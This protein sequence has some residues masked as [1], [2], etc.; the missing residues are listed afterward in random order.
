MH[1]SAM[2][3]G[4]LFF[5]NYVKKNDPIIVELGSQ[6]VNG[7]LRE[8]APKDAQYIGVILLKALGST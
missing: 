4:K 5:E 1:P 8:V 2:L 6:D 3:H 7:S